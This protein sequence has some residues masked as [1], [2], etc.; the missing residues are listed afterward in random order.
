KTAFEQNMDVSLDAD[1]PTPHENSDSDSPADAL[2]DPELVELAQPFVGQ[3]NTLISTT[4]W[5]KGR[6]IGEWRETLMANGAPATEFS[7]E[8]W[9]R[10]V[11]GVTSPHVGRLRRVF[12]RFGTV[13]ESYDGIYWSHFLAALDWDDAPLWLEGAARESWSVSSMREM[14]WQAHGAVD[15]QRPNNSQIVEVDLDEDV[16]LPAQGDARERNYDD[17]AGGIQAGPIPEGPDFGDA[18]E[19]ASLDGGREGSTTEALTEEESSGNPIQPFAGLPALPD[20]LSDAVETMKLAI[21]RHKSGGWTE[22][23]ADDVARYLEA[24]GVM[25]RA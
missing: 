7:D 17:D 20:D 24:L 10:R 21:L 3:W 2:D 1:S 8:A 13:R 18:E 25:L 9:V 11:G 22:I 23:S 5:D 6:I 14:R 4:N 16:V 12:E 15:S 19:L